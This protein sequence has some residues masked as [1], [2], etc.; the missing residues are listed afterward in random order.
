MDLNNVNSIDYKDLPIIQ[1]EDFSSL[2]IREAVRN[3]VQPVSGWV[4]RSRR[5]A[6]N[7]GFNASACFQ[8]VSIISAVPFL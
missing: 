2:I 4:W 3:S 1:Y 8:I 5:L 7:S 6:I